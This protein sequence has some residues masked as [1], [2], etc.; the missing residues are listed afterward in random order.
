MTSIVI[1]KTNSNDL[2]LMALSEKD[3][4]K[5]PNQV[6]IDTDDKGISDKQFNALHVWCDQVAKAINRCA[7]ERGDADLYRM[8][9]HP[10]AKKN[11]S[12][13]SERII[14]VPWD[15]DSVKQDLYKPTLKRYKGML[16]TKDQSTAEPNVICEALNRA[17]MKCHNLSLPMWPSKRG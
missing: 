12:T 1:Q 10:F 11:E 17:Y 4:A 8:I 14:R 9:V 3:Y 5:L 2:C 7:G 15:K 13:L 16:S 6:V